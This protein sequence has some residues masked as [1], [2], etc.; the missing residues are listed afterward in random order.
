MNR[1]PR[2]MNVLINGEE[3]AREVSH[4]DKDNH[5]YVPKLEVGED[6][7]WLVADY[8]PVII[9]VEFA[10]HEEPEECALCGRP[11]FVRRCTGCG[12][13]PA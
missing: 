13:E 7:E 12:Y 6:I 1:I 4:Y 9:V 8:R 11:F 5:R 10:P 2:T 3:Q